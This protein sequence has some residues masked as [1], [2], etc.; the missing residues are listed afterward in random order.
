MK[1]H[2]FDY[3]VLKSVS[4]SCRKSCDFHK[5]DILTHTLTVKIKNIYAG[6]R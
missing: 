1:L 6:A 3:L 4:I 5:L 2:D